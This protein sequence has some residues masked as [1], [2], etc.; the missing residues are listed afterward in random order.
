MIA[1]RKEHIWL[2]LPTVITLVVITVFP[3]IYAV[4]VSLRDYSLAGGKQ[5]HAFNHFQNFGFVLRDPEFYNSLWVTVKFSALCLLFELPLGLGL[6]VLFSQPKYKLEPFGLLLMLPMA[7]APAVIGL[8]FRWFYSAEVGIIGYMLQSIGITPPSWSADRTAALFSIIISDVWE[9]TPYVFL[10]CM[11][12]LRA[13]DEEVYEAAAIDG[14]SGWKQFRYVTFPLMIPTIIIV[15][16]L[17][18]IPALKEFDKIFIITD[19]GPGI[20]TEATTLYIFKQFLW[21]NN[22]G[23]AT[24]AALLLLLGII[25]ISQLLFAYLRR[26][27]EW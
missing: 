26:H 8:V 18:A 22:L 12:G 4:N 27:E 21:F 25:L 23:T 19:G 11:A 1:R 14:A 20:A 10:I 6:A 13:I 3:L 16:M 17:R 2:L 9:W 24:A 7:I 5:V 15:L